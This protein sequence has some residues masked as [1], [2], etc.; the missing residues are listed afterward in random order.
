LKEAGIEVVG[1]V[2][3]ESEAR[4]ENPAFF[5][6]A[7]EATPFLALKLALTLDGKIAS[8][9][10]R[11]TRITGPAA[12]RE[13]HRLRTGFDAILVGS[14]TLQADDPR[15][16]VRLAR[17]GARPP[18]RLLVDS[19]AEVRTEAA[20]L[21]DARE[22]PVHIFTR[23]DAPEADLE[24]LEAAG[25]HVHPVDHGRGGLDLSALLAASW[26]LGIRSILC[27]GG[28]RLGS[29]LLREGHVHRLY[30]FSAPSALGEGGLPAFSADAEDLPWKRYAP[31]AKPELHGRDT[32]MVLDREAG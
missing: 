2:W 8:A 31:A 26:E 3:S 5:H 10:G 27:E 20:V 4:A 21:E 22:V 1:P 25:A 18:R 28:A 6:T 13:A 14:G 11:R 7:R 30:L 24:R 23:R 12:E 15:L 9:P 16:T 32:L 19:R 17:P 29:A